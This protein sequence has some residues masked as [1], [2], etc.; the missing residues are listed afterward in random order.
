MKKT[1]A[2]LF[3]AIILLSFAIILIGFHPFHVIFSFFGYEAYMLVSHGMMWAVWRSSWLIGNT[4]QVDGLDFIKNLPKDRPMIVVSNHQ[5]EFEIAC[6]G[7]LFSKGSHHL[8]Y[9]AKKELA[10]GIPSVSWNIRYGGHGVIN[11]NNREQALKAIEKFAEQVAERKWSAYIYPEGTR[12]KRSNAVRPFK[13][14]GF[15]KL[16]ECLPDAF[17]IPIAIENFWTVKS[18]PVVPFSKMRI[19]IFPPLDPKDFENSEA[20]LKYCEK[21]IREELQTTDT[22]IS[23]NFATQSSRL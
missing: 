10:Y 4:T 18:I 8:K 17:I 13:T 3:T 1:I 5:S 19:K 2:W 11:R 23:E 6:L 21:L 20:L 14:A 7:Y 16:C 15:V 12:N 9:V 22:D